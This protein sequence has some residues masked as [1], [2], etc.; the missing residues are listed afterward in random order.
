MMNMK[1]KI[2]LP[3][4]QDLIEAIRF[5]EENG[6][7][8]LAENRMLLLSANVMAQLQASLSTVLGRERSKYFLMR[9]G[10]Q[11]GLQDAELSKKIRP[12]W[13]TAEQ[14]FLAGPQ[15]HAI[16]GM[17][18][19]V[20]QALTIDVAAGVF[21]GRFNWYESYEVSNYLKQYG[22]SRDPVCWTLLGYASGFSS[23]FMG[24]TIVFKEEQCAAM[25]HS[26]C[27][28]VGKPEAE[29]DELTDM[30]SAMLSESMPKNIFALRTDFINLQSSVAPSAPRKSSLTIGHSQP[31]LDVCALVDRASK[32]Q[33]SVLLQGAIGVGKGAFAYALH[34]QSSRANKPFITVNCACLPP[35]LVEA[36]LFGIAKGALPG[37]TETRIG[38]IEQ[39]AGGTIY[40]SEILALSLRGQTRLLMLLEEKKLARLGQAAMT[41]IDVRLLVSCKEDLVQAVKDGRFRADLYYRLNVM[42]IEIPSLA[43]RKEDIV[44]L[45]N[46]FLAKHAQV[47]QKN[48][49]GFSDRANELM[50]QYDWP[51]NIREL[52]HAVER[53]LIMTEARQHIDA[54][55]LFPNH[56]DE[57]TYVNGFDQEGRLASVDG[58]LPEHQRSLIKQLLQQELNLEALEQGLILGALKDANNNISEAA[59]RL[60]LTRP[61]LAYRMKKFNI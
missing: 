53:G 21:F 4:S 46:H 1:Q 7:I 44:L 37:V 22:P 48:V 43:E 30:E 11:I 47:H 10:F 18:K 49:L 32:T 36:E 41:D 5:D 54:S 50:M 35:D 27:A 13:A 25:G 55:H 52:E 40:I 60:G 34:K 6:K 58:K 33:V 45:A 57:T 20:P 12:N 14:V 9:F 17:V 8:W 61:A 51:G 3:K 26:H 38:K 29:W 24:K 19:V 15:F 56:Q 2:P 59:R 42:S 16:R 39:A 23:G 31:Y 28:I